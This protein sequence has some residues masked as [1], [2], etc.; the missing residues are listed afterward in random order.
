[1]QIPPAIETADI[2]KPGA[3]ALRASGHHPNARIMAIIAAP[4]GSILGATAFGI[5]GWRNGRQQILA[6]QNGLPCDSLN[7]LISDDAGNLW[8]NAE[9]SLIE[10][11]K[12]ERQLWWEHP[13]SKLSLLRHYLACSNIRNTDIQKAADLIRVGGDAERH[14]RLA[15]GWA[16][17]RQSTIS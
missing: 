12:Q 2:V 17:L 9:C 14:R 10:I 11:P 4:D 13:E 15:R 7:T 8:L 5:V 1:M 3:G 6:V 16:R